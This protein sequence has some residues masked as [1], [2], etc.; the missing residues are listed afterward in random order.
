MIWVNTYG[1]NIGEITM[2][3]NEDVVRELVSAYES[4]YYFLF[5]DKNIINIVPSRKDF[6]EDLIECVFDSLKCLEFIH[7]EEEGLRYR[8]LI[9]EYI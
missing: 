9:E 3:G 4:G 5:F 1:L 2:I 7:S 8:K 6:K